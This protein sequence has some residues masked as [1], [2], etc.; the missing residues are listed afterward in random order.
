MWRSA[1]PKHQSKAPKGFF[2]PPHQE[3]NSAGCKKGLTVPDKKLSHG[4]K[5]RFNVISKI[6]NVEKYI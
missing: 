4:Q 2:K 3:H 5:K 6:P 1:L